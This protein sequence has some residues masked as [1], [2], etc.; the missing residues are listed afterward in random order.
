LIK[1][2]VLI[3]GANGFVG[4]NLTKLLS[5]NP[6]YEVFAMVRSKASVSYLYEFQK[7]PITGDN[8]FELIEAD[9]KD[10]E[11]IEKAMSGI[12]TVV[13]LAGM[14]TDWGQWSQYF[15]L[16]VE[17]T[18][19]ILKGASSAGVSKVIYLSSVTV[20][21]MTGHTYSDETVPADVQ[22]FPYGETKKM[23]EDLILQ[24]AEDTDP[25]IIRHSAIVR[26]GF[27]IYGS[28]DKNSFINVIDAVNKGSFLFLNKG[29]RLV[30][31]VYVENL[32]SAIDE[33]IKSQSIKGVYNVLD[34]NMTWNEWIKVW[35]DA[36]KVKM[37]KITV[38]FWYMY[39]FVLVLEGI[40]KFFRIKSAP[41]LTMYR[42]RIMHKDLAFSNSKI[43]EEIGFESPV[44][45]D[46]AVK[47]TLEFYYK[48]IK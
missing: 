18:R 4:S 35:A 46:D 26:P 43:K 31:H 17:G 19:R 40:F 9:L 23:G 1:E 20:H 22:N 28:Y 30:S 25:H 7:D 38:S 5:S 47:S 14:V 16:N 32:C 2:K 42:L 41:V 15:D 29:K 6:F 21:A 45:L 33:L 10:D 13:H 48:T 24:W 39:P 11:S 3:T 44:S 36:L 12:D 27:V 37:P 34:G 8:L